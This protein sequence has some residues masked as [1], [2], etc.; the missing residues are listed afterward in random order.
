MIC[1]SSCSRFHRGHGR[2]ALH[3][4]SPFETHIFLACLSKISEAARCSVFRSFVPRCR[5]C[6]DSIV[7]HCIIGQPVQ[8]CIFALGQFISE[9]WLTHMVSFSAFWNRSSTC[10]N[11]TLLQ[12]S[13]H[14]EP[15]PQSEREVKESPRVDTRPSSLLAQL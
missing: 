5:R 2:K 13:P 1:A 12:S 15:L 6:P 7:G 8:V 9:I 14:D 11:Q 3:A 4:C 10:F